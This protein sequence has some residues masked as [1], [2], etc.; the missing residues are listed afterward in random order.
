MILFVRLYVENMISQLVTFMYET[1]LK[2]N[3]SVA[4]YKY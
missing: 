3:G 1:K 2:G 4:V